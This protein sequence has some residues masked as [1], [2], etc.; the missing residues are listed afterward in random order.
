MSPYK[1]PAR[2]RRAKRNAQSAP[3]EGAAREKEDARRPDIVRL[4]VSDVLGG[5]REALLTH[6]G[7]DYRLRITFRGKLLL[8]K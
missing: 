7:E 4:R 8:T 2:R 1:V 3:S 6:N 5:A